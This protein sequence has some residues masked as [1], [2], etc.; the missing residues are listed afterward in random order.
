MLRSLLT[1]GSIGLARHGVIADAATQCLVSNEAAS[2]ARRCL[3]ASTAARAAADGGGACLP[4][5]GSEDRILLR[6]LVFHGYHGV[7]P[8][9]QVLGQ[10][11]V[12]D[13]SLSADLAAAGRSDDLADTVSYAAVYE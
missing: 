1:V 5:C 13:A 3:A 9:E 11:F 8:E 6:G 12:V 4:A 7:L 2:A 10:K